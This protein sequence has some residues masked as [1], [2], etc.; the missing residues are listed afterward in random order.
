MKV[1]SF[2]LS[3]EEYVESVLLELGPGMHFHSQFFRDKVAQY[4]IC[5]Q[6]LFIFGKSVIR[7]GLQLIYSIF[8]G[9][10][11]TTTHTSNSNVKKRRQLQYRMCSFDAWCYKQGVHIRA[12]YL[13]FCRRLQDCIQH[14][15]HTSTDY[16]ILL[17]V[18]I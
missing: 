6:S 2:Q 5:I 12:L 1:S 8:V 11:N 13:Q 4:T 9:T 7:I 18:K 10:F 16:R 3:G 15:R 17:S 14:M